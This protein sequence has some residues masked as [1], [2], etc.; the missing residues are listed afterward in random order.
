MF[1]KSESSLDVHL[2]IECKQMF[3]TFNF[4]QALLA[5]TNKSNFN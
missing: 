4:V 5:Q 2:I 3:L 1:Y